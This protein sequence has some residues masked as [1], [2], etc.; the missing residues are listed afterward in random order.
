MRHFQ[1]ILSRIGVEIQQNAR[2]L[3]FG[4]GAGSTVSFL[5][6]L[7]YD[8]YGYDV[9]D[10][11]SRRDTNS[12][13]PFIK[14]GS[15]LD[16]RLPFEDNTF[17]LV[18]SDQVFE[19]VQDQGTAW[20]ELYRVTK[21][22][23]HGLHVIPARYMPVEGHMFVPFGSVV[24]YR[25]WFMLWAFLGIRNSYQRNLST[26]E[27]VDRNLAFHFDG[28]RYVPTSQYKV[29]WPEIGFAYKF[30]TR[31]YLDEHHR[32]AVRLFG[33]LSRVFPPLLWLYRM[34][35]SRHVYLKKNRI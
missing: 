22:G 12:R 16:L 5:R 19:H 11:L 26:T 33:A 7:G 3:D 4:C 32:Y 13:S 2:I 30:L 25:W 23:G 1:K 20:R 6:G 31:E 17:D 10:E 8:A 18:L 9:D 29:M 34:M 21:P 15:R 24:T 35:Q 14:I 27:I 28:L